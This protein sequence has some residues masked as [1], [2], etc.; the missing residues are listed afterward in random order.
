[1]VAVLTKLNYPIGNDYRQGMKKTI[2][3]RNL[4][5]GIRFNMVTPAR[6]ILLQIVSSLVAV[7]K[8]YRLT[9]YTQQM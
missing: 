7:V 3:N 8:R 9:A 2:L 4:L 6:L 5:G 1:M